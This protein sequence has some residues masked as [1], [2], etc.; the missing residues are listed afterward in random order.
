MRWH[1]SCR[2]RCDDTHAQDGAEAMQPRTSTAAKP[3]ARHWAWPYAPPGRASAIV[4]A[5]QRRVAV[6]VPHDSRECSHVH[7]ATNGHTEVGASALVPRE[8]VAP[9]AL[10]RH[11]VWSG[12]PSAHA[13]AFVSTRQRRAT[14]SVTHDVK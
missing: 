13:A 6:S 9:N 12:A 7:T 3:P 10:A 11:W 14:V 8:S 1:S 5:L 2:R 4:S